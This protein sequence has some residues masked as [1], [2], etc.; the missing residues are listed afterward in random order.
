MRKRIPTD[1]AG[2]QA[3]DSAGAFD[4][5]RAVVVD[6]ARE[7]A[8]VH[9]VGSPADRRSAKAAAAQPAPRLTNRSTL[10]RMQNRHRLLEVAETRGDDG[11]AIDRPPELGLDRGRA[12]CELRRIRGLQ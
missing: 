4:D 11:R 3:F 10:P 9:T 6:I 8:H 2:N 5:K 7:A 12:I 1:F